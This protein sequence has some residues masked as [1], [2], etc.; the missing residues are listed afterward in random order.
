MIG[1]LFFGHASATCSRERS[2]RLIVGIAAQ[3][4]IAI[5]NARLYEDAKRAAEERARLLDAERAARAE[6]ERVSLMKDEFLATLSHELRTPLNAMLGWSEIL[7]S[8]ARGETP[9][10]AADSRPSRATRARRPSSSRT[11]ST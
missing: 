11:C 6:I 2:E 3:A 5:D 8:R 4:A 10:R 9:T 7:L 1:G